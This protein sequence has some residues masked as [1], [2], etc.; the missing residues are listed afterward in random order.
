MT[1][2]EK[3]REAQRLLP[4]ETVRRAAGL[5]G[6]A[7]LCAAP[8]PEVA[9]LGFISSTSSHGRAQLKQTRALLLRDGF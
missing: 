6:H 7:L 9:A 4:G 8:A 2:E 3:Q 1:Q 5:P